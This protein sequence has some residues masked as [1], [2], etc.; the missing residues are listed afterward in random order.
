MSIR[1]QASTGEI[2]AFMDD[3]AVAEGESLES[4]ITSFRDSKVVAIGG[5][6]IPV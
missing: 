4:S 5:K 1:V 3:D 2:G 6:A